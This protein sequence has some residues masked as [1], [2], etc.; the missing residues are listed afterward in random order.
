LVRVRKKIICLITQSLLCV[1]C[2]SAKAD[3]P[4]DCP[5]PPL[6]Q[7]LH[8]EITGVEADTT[9]SADINPG[10]C[11]LPG[12]GNEAARPADDL[13]PSGQNVRAPREC[14][15]DLVNT[16][17]PGTNLS[18]VQPL[19]ASHEADRFSLDGRMQCAPTVGSDQATS[20]QRDPR[21]DG[22]S[23]LQAATQIPAE[24]CGYHVVVPVIITQAIDSKT[25]AVGD[26][27]QAVL[28]DD[29]KLGGKTYVNK[30]ALIKGHI[31]SNTSPRTLSQSLGSDRRFNSRAALLVQFDEI[32]D[33]SGN[34]IAI[35]GSFSR[36]SVIMPQ[37]NL[38]NRE[39][40]VDY[41]GQIIKAEPILTPTQRNV[42]NAGRSLT[43]APLP[44]GLLLNVLGVP[45]VMGIAGA[46]DP[47][48]AYNKPV[49]QSVEHRRLKGLMYAFI[50]NLPGAFLVQSMVEKGN[51][52][53]LNAGDEL[54]LDLCLKHSEPDTTASPVA[55]TDVHGAVL[56]DRD[57]NQ[58]MNK[59]LMA[60]NPTVMNDDGLVAQT[61]KF[62]DTPIAP[63]GT[64]YG[65]R[66]L[67]LPGNG[68]G[69][70]VPTGVR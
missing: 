4:V 24:L 43:V 1:F 44:G 18:V 60:V 52:I 17:S 68:G 12:G 56:P 42:Y 63:S 10:G 34:H 69:R 61:A 15:A 66:S 62:D 32:D 26:P 20:N 36:Q 7:T 48:F 14:S 25:A 50:T 38:P 57:V 27:I 67:I 59:L 58:D 16:S 46:A 70:L 53:M 9:V 5:A 65:A 11:P 13:G 47:A 23:A 21:A 49:D 51:E 31:V 33:N 8:E 19:A 22:T 35:A 40:K 2:L 41:L 30:G 28:K 3:E 37:A 45:A 39:V 54:A 6:F 29:I 64:F 55:L